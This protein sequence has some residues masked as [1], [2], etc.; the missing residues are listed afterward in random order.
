MLHRS[1]PHLRPGVDVGSERDRAAA[2][3][4]PTRRRRNHLCQASEES[5][6]FYQNAWS[7]HYL[8]KRVLTISNVEDYKFLPSPLC[9]HP[10]TPELGS[11]T[12]LRIR[13]CVLVTP[14]PDVNWCD[15]Y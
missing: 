1:P 5:K 9:P 10:T 4:A 12:D 8:K 7:F 6:A 3:A 14:S 15:E 11:V 13:I 2:D